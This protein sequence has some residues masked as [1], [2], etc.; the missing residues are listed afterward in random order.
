MGHQPAARA[1]R[2]RPARPSARANRD[3]ATASRWTTAT[4]LTPTLGLGLSLTRSPTLSLSLTL[5][6]LTLTLT[7]S[8]T[9]T[10]D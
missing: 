9:L 4:L 3:A 7:L 8:L 5:L 1:D 2:A 6:T 10:T